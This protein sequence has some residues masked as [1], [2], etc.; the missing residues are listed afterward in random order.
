MQRIS[1]Y[2]PVDTKKRI[3]ITAK[4]K[5]QE[6]SE[7]I[8]RALDEG[9]KK[10]HPIA[11]SAKALLELAKLAEQLPDQ[12]GKPKNLS[13]DHDFYAWGGQQKDE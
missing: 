11:T 6:E 2:I 12:P 13:Q 3:S 1:V 9:L 4:A 5:N 10:I 7:V 8:R